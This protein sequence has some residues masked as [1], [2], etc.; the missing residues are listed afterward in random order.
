M[1]TLK[2]DMHFAA[3]A[4]LC[5][6]GAANAAVVTWNINA[7]IPANI[8]G[9]YIN[10]ETQQ[11]GTAGSGVAGWDINPYGATALSFFSSTGGGYMRTPGATSGVAGNLASGTS[12]GA[13]GSW[14][15]S[16]TAVTFGSNPGNW[17]LNAV[18]Y[19]GFRFVGGDGQVRYG[20]GVMQVG[21]NAATRTLLSVAYE[22]T[23]GAAIAV[24]AVPAPG[25]LALLG[26]AGLASRRRR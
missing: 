5:A 25:A 26:V 7:V 21:A 24:G 20:Y 13:S 18:N 12:I 6:A 16:T 14:S 19:F 22:S 9:L 4:A 1:K 2:L 11:T 10:V 23:A 17:Q 3:A 15:T 8:D